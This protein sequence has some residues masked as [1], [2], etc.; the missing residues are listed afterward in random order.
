M[1]GWAEAST[2]G[3]LLLRSASRRPDHEALVFPHARFTY[4]DLAERVVR[5]ARS[6]A[7]L[8]VGR[9][10]H[11][12]LLMPNSP[13]FVFAFF[14]TQLL[15]AVAV[16]INTRYRTRELAH[17]VANG[18][19]VVLLTSDIVDD[20]VDFVERLCE[21]LPGL[22]DAPDPLRLRLAAAPKL[23]TVVLL[24]DRHSDGCLSRSRFDELA[25]AVEESSV[26]AQRARVRV[27][28]V[29]LI[30]FTSGTTA[31]PKG[32]LLT[33]EAMVR[34]W[35]A[36]ADR[37]RITAEE[38]IWNPLPMFHMSCI[39][40]MIF[41]FDLGATL[42]SMVHFEPAVALELIEREQVTWVQSV[43]PPIA[44][45]LVR[46]PDFAE[47]DLS[48][49]R[50]L[51]NVAPPDTL[52][53]IQEAFAPAV[54]IGGHFGMTE[55][56]GAIT[57]NEWD[58]TPDQ[59]AETTG[60]PLPG[61]EVRVVDPATGALLGPEQPGEL[62]IRGF[63]LF[64]GYYKDP[65]S[66]AAAM[67]DDGWLSSGDLGSADR[68]GLITYLGRLKEMLKVGGENVAPSEIESHLST[69]SAIKLVQVVGVPDDRLDEVPAAFIELVPGRL[70][71]AS[72]VIEY[73]RGAI[74]SFKVPRYVRF[75]T[76]WPMSATK[77]QKVR[78]REQFLAEGGAGAA[79]EAERLDRS[80][81]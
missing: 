26:L 20:Q 48:R 19:L 55:A 11:V 37:L 38:R 10:D 79:S 34:V 73:C 51:L 49:V 58:A 68:D 31:Q 1:T 4:E 59:Q 5:T 9:G 36:V 72:E 76:E 13:D 67:T 53:L 47:R 41:A 66:T 28:D 50:G 56:A 29:A 27:R 32:A 17:V 14:A 16:P 52:R 64:E 39:G 74:A 57:C 71:S 62:Q 22:T 30:L 42:V 2:M 81:S 78:L 21:A 46:H 75:V 24:G 60:A 70:L 25:A 65:Q 6:L 54:Q 15:G 69:H 35:V 7:A 61:V 77:V 44:M 43:F 33:H 40:P 63:G 3:D 45:G 12:G 18:D 80:R 23:R 8:G